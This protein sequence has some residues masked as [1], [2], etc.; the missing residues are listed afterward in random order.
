[1][2]L[3][4]LY[5]AQHSEKYFKDPLEFKPERWLRENRDQHQAFR[6]LPFGFGA[7]MCVGKK[8]ASFKQGY[9]VCAVHLH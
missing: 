1:M 9:S 2:I 7:R 3:Q 6:H 4:E 5:C 8:R